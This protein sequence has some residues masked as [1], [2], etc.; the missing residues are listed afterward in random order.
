MYAGLPAGTTQETDENH[1]KGEH[2]RWFD[3]SGECR[4]DKTRLDEGVVVVVMCMSCVRSP[5]VSRAGL[6]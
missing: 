1:R 3:I 2:L 6:Q 5:A 4:R